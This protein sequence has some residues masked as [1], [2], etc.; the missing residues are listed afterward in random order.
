MHQNHIFVFCF[1]VE[2][3][4]VAL[5]TVGDER[6]ILEGIYVIFALCTHLGCT[7]R[8]LKSESKYKCPCHGSGFTKQGL[9]FEGPAPRALERL[10]IALAPDGQIIIDKSKSYWF[11]KGQ[12]D[13]PGAKLFV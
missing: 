4:V 10:K 8:W 11:E 1:F 5:G 12:W 7:P 3:Y 6:D 13:K 2:S 9:N